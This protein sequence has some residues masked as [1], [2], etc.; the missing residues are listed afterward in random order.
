M[1]P[2][3]VADVRTRTPVTSETVFEAASLSKPVFAYAVMRLAT[4]GWIDLDAP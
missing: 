1:L 3:G 4:E 2:F